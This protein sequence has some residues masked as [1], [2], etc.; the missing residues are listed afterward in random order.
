MSPNIK[1]VRR[2]YNLNVVCD[3]L[4]RT[5]IEALQYPDHFEDRDQADEPWFLFGEPAG[6][7][8]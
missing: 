8:R 1:R 7:P 5:L 4:A 2:Q 6:K 3:V